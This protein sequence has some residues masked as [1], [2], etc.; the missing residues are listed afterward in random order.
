MGW[1]SEGSGVFVLSKAT[2]PWSGSGIPLSLLEWLRKWHSLEFIGV[3]AGVDVDDGHDARRTPDADGHCGN[4]TRVTLGV[5]T[6]SHPAHPRSQ[7]GS[8]HYQ[9][10]SP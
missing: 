1:R 6:F 7:G 8:E 10:T 3:D 4:D 5:T 9:P 2:S